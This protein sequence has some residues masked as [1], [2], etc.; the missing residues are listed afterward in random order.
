[1][2]WTKSY[3]LR[4]DD[5]IDWS[6]PRFPATHPPVVADVDG[7]GFPEIVMCA[8][9]VPGNHIVGVPFLEFR[10]AKTR[11][12]DGFGDISDEVIVGGT[13]P[14]MY[15]GREV[16]LT[17]LNGDG[18]DDLIF[19]DTG[20]DGVPYPG[21]ENLI[22]MSDGKGQL[23]DRSADFSVGENFT[24]S[25][26]TGDID[27]DGQPEIMF[28]D[29]ENGS[30]FAIMS[31]LQD[32]SVRKNAFELPGTISPNGYTTSEIIDLDGDG[33][34]EVILGG[35]THDIRNPTGES[36][37]LHWNG[38][39]F[40][41]DPL[42]TVENRTN[43]DTDV[44]DINGDGRLDIV[45]LQTHPWYVGTFIQ[46]LIQQ[47][48]GSFSDQTE[49]VFSSGTLS[50][51]HWSGGIEFADLDGDGDLDMAM[52]VQHE[53][54]RVYLQNSFGVFEQLDFS[55]VG[56]G[57]LPGEPGD[58]IALVDVDF[59]NVPE[60]VTFGG[61]YLHVWDSNALPF[62]NIYQGN[63]KRN[64][65]VGSDQA[66]RFLGREGD[67][68]LKG[69][70]GNDRIFGGTGKDRLIGNEGRDSLNGGAGRDVLLGGSGKDNLDGGRGRDVLVGGRGRDI[71]DGGHG[72]DIFVFGMGD[73]KDIIRDFKDDLDKLKLEG[74]LWEG[75][76]AVDE[77]LDAYASVSGKNVVFS[78]DGGEQIILRGILDVSILADDL[79]IM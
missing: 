29:L 27:G 3:H 73:G 24:H 48:D 23:I 65:F 76:L 21:A 49:S 2:T 78:F 68:W 9:T 30:K 55:R 26:S 28:G 61:T 70:A 31:Y 41:V 71:L 36:H 13:R 59:D 35:E 14:E 6:Y 10:L 46:V 69:A 44:I 37:L 12:P 8:F 75:E 51:D 45:F 17:D 62:Q 5:Y 66:E 52:T 34:D 67:D 79:I 22:L 74:A 19:A 57:N 11:Y 54:A 40:D 53:H 1:M 33:R 18:W 50:D 64:I 47:A 63:E 38:A 72:K 25:V 39:G 42:P 56:L 20:L 43:L 16:V 32:G 60:L 7:D 58:A 4:L 77:V 15:F